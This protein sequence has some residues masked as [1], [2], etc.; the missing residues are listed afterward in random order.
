MLGQALR[1]AG[2]QQLFSLVSS[3]SVDPRLP[4]DKIGFWGSSIARGKLY[5]VYKGTFGDYEN[6][7]V[8]IAPLKDPKDP[9]GNKGSAARNEIRMM[10]QFSATDKFVRLLSYEV[11]IDRIFLA[12]EAGKENLWSFFNRVYFG[13]NIEEYDLPKLFRELLQGVDYMHRKQ[14]VHRN[15]NLK[16]IY[17]YKTSGKIC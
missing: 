8:K 2:D 7:Y 15:I 4:V 10:Q 13:D 6:V 17:I 14:I 1:P 5:Q 9:E 12:I 16:N 3:T 11:S